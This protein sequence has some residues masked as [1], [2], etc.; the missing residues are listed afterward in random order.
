MEQRVVGEQEQ[1]HQS[2]ARFLRRGELDE[3][4]ERTLRIQSILVIVRLLLLRWL[5]MMLMRVLRVRLRSGHQTARGRCAGQ[6]RASRRWW[7][8]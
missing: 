3:E 7:R 6:E 8:C 1:H 5:L 2:Q 4:R